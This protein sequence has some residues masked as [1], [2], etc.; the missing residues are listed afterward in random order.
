MR[1]V[2]WPLHLRNVESLGPLRLEMGNCLVPE[3][4]RLSASWCVSIK[5]Q[6]GLLKSAP[7]EKL[8]ARLG[9]VFEGVAVLNL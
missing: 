9:S 7:C 3:Q 6:E 8:K 4:R 5:R 1:N 2:Y